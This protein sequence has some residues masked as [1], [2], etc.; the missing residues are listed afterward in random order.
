M[1]RLMVISGIVGL[2]LL[3][4]SA[5]S[6]TTPTQFMD[7][8]EIVPGMRGFGLSVFEGS[9]I[10]TFSVE[11]LGVMKNMFYA[12]HDLIMVRISGPYVD[13]AGVI[14]GMSGSPV[15]IDGKLVGALAYSFGQ[16]PKEPIGAVT[17]ISQMLEIQKAFTTDSPHQENLG[18]SETINEPG[19]GLRDRASPSGAA[20]PL[21][22][23]SFLK[24][25]SVP[26][27]CSG[28]DPAVLRLFDETFRK[29]GLIPIQGGGGSIQGTAGSITAH[30]LE[31]GSAVAVQ[32]IRGDFNLSATGTVTYRDGKT[33]L[34]FGHPF[35]W[36]GA[37]DVP[38]AKAEIITVIPDLASS[39][40]LS[41]TTD[42]VGSVLW[43]HTNGLYGELGRS[44]RMI[45]VHIVY[46]SGA[47]PADKYDFEVMMGKEWT[48]T[49]V[50]MAVSN[51]ILGRGRL[52][53]E[54]TIRLEG[55]VGMKGRSDIVLHDLF[56]GQLTL[57]AMT[58]DVTGLLSTVLENPFVTPH[59]ESIDITLHSSNERRTA[60][61]EGVW[62]DRNE[63]VPGD[64]LGVTVF[65][66]PYRGDRVVKKIAIPLPKNMEG[67][68]LQVL[69][70]TG[71]AVTQH[72]L[73][74]T[75]HRFRPEEA[76][77]LITLL[78]NQ[79]TNNDIYIRLY[80]SNPGGA[81]KGTEMTGLPPSVL[82]VMNSDR[83]NGSFIPINE[84]VLVEARIETDYVVTGQSRS[85]LTVKR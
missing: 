34:A 9:R 41:N 72:E 4:G 54:R 40:K 21:S 82:S 15:Y 5:Q 31:P 70:G 13:K 56:S 20:Q 10:D 52:G 63:V 7:T 27:V 60:Q 36:T 62:Y 19:Q 74:S 50:N 83:T 77:Q 39:T 65:L 59:I 25:I 78:N 47:Q 79:R 84:L 38:M 3:A 37:L 48:P 6:Q 16:L 69:V 1:R 22:T 71:Q 8:K 75:P 14:A 49:L 26:M 45:P 57:P 24:P 76:N 67:G 2:L 80:Q 11:V 23:G 68:V 32:L 18:D 35:L 12:K 33:I 46:Q 85:Q 55:R 51:T 58:S 81:V 43:D 28:F 30:T 53:G 17:P 66:R 42:A 73:R 44:A 29:K 64:T 61:I